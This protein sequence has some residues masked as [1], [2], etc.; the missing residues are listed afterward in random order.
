MFYYAANVYD[1]VKSQRCQQLHILTFD[2]RDLKTMFAANCYLNSASFSAVALL[3][4]GAYG[5]YELGRVLIRY[6]YKVR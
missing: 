3:T 5:C 4:H 2:E 6:V 1:V